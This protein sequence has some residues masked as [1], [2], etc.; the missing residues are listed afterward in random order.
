MKNLLRLILAIGLL[1]LLTSSFALPP[2]QGSDSSKWSNCYGSLNLA[3]GETYVGEWKEKGVRTGQG[4]Y[5]YS[6]GTKYIGEHKNNEANGQGSFIWPDG[7]KYSGNV[8]EGKLNGLGTFTWKDGEKYIGEYVAG[9]RNGQGT[10]IFAN[11]NKYVGEYKDDK[12]TG[13]GTYFLLA[14]DQWKGDKYVG[15]FKDGKFSGQGTYYHL[16]DNQWKGMKYVG[17]WNNNKKNGRGIDYK[18]DGQVSLTGL[19]NDGDFIASQYVDPNI[20]TRIAKGNTGPSAA[21]T[22]RLENERKAAQLEEDRK[23]IEEEKRQIALERQRIEAL[24]GQAL[25]SCQ[26][27][28]VS[29]WTNCF[30]TETFRNGDRSAAEYKEGRR[31]GQGMFTWADGDRYVGEF[32]DDKR[33]GRGIFYL[34]NGSISQTGIWSDGTLVTSQYVDPNSFTRIAKSNSAPSASEALRL[35]NER[36]AAQLEEDR[37]KF[38]EEKR[39]AALERQRLEGQKAQAQVAPDNRRRLALVIGN[40][41][42]SSMP[43]LNN[44]INDA[45]SMSEALRQANFEVMSY[46]NLDKRRMEEVLR[47]FT[48]KLG[49]DDVGL[50]YFSGHGIQADNRNFLIPVSEN[51]KKTSEVPY[52]GIDVNRVMDNL[53]DA[54]NALNIVVLDACRSS[55]PDARGGMSRGLTVTDAPQGSIIAYATSPGKT[56]SDGEGG[57]SPYTKSLIKAM[58]RKGVK[59]EDVFK[60]VRQ[61]VIR[62]TNGEQTPSETSYLVGDFYFRP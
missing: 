56:A 29:R 4:T 54:K 11:G 61:S 24:K 20:F 38:E 42:Y 30:G 14:D 8:F 21:E 39:Q 1:T 49:R 46:S 19:F 58:Q 36:K 37:R 7:S 15:E 55:L 35:E 27:N 3:N 33:N 57:N 32:K 6:D 44:A 43:R 62:D 10:T 9:H 22:L 50:F 17:E 23:R 52:E 51:V 12:R 47:N 16:A 60:E 41:N 26:G 18:A 31:T 2:C 25:P 48:G 59:I 13:L 40:D 5:T 53:K 28:D 45:K 34:A